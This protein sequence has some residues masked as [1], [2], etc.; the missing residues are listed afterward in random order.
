MSV[1]N[2]CKRGDLLGLVEIIDKGGNVCEVDTKG[3][4]CLHF[5]AS[6][7]RE[8]LAQILLNSGSDVM[9]KDSNG[10]TPLHY[11][12]HDQVVQ[13]LFDYGAELCAR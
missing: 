12:G 10:N 8:D 2:I 1:I 6:M 9:A 13:L 5:A 4:S 3:R 7:G 11:S